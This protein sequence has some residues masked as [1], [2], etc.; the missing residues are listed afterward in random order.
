MM[1]S[2]WPVG[3]LGSLTTFN[4]TA[5]WAKRVIPIKNT[6]TSNHAPDVKRF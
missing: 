1:A 4:G 5:E 6:L 3:E 2:Q